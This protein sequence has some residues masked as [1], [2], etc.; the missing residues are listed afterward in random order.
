M[1][2]LN[3]IAVAWQ[4]YAKSL[5]LD[6]TVPLITS[7]FAKRFRN[8]RA[9]DTRFKLPNNTTRASKLNCHRNS[10]NRSSKAGSSLTISMTYITVALRPV[11]KQRFWELR[12]SLGNLRRALVVLMAAMI[13]P[14]A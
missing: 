14:R 2:T 10:Q 9:T 5:H 7:A 4:R 13:T 1:M 12:T 8:M 6:R 11:K 3:K